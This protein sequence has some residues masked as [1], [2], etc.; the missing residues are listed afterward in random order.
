MSRLRK[1]ILTLSPL[2]LIGWLLDSPYTIGQKQFNNGR[3]DKAEQSFS[4]VG[5]NL[6]NNAQETRRSREYDDCQYALGM[7]YLYGIGTTERKEKEGIKLLEAAADSANSKATQNRALYL[8]GTFYIKA[9]IENRDIEADESEYLQNLKKR[10]PESNPVCIAYSEGELYLWQAAKNGY[11]PAQY[12]L[13]QYYANVLKIGD[14]ERRKLFAR[15]WL[16]TAINH[17]QDI[18]NIFGEKLTKTQLENAQKLC[19]QLKNQ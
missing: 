4:N 6:T 15:Y 13:G 10:V 14:E 19:D 17:T 9:E 5:K 8:L 7:M 1:L 11:V 3:F 12:E 18:T 2:S 16:K